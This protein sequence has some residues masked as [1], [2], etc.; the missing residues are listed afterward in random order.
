MD[1]RWPWRTRTLSLNFNLTKN[2]VD[3][4][5]AMGRFLLILLLCQIKNVTSQRIDRIS[6]ERKPTHTSALKTPGDNG[7]SIKILGSPPVTFYKP[8]HNY[9]GMYFKFLSFY[10]VLLNLVSMFWLLDLTSF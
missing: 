8:G 3:F 1:C 2:R 7:F 5:T 4:Q 6:C 10:F 9:Q